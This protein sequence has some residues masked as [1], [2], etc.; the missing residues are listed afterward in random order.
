MENEILKSPE[1]TAAATP[2]ERAVL[3]HNRINANAKIVADSIVEIGR[4]LKTMR[5]EKLYEEIGCGSFAEYCEQKTPIK[6]RQAY[7]FIK[8]YEKYGEE[9]LAEISYL[10]VTKLV[11]L[12]A[13]EDND[14][15]EIIDSG[16]ADNISASELKKKIDEL[17]KANE[18][19]TL[20]LDEKSKEESKIEKLKNEYEKLKAEKAAQESV[21]AKQAERN[22]ELERQ[23]KE[24]REK[25][26]EVAV[27]KPSEEELEEIRRA[28]AEKA[29]NAAKVKH[30]EEIA[31]LREKADDE[32]L[33]AVNAARK[34][35]AEE[36]E[37]LKSQ[38]SD[39]QSSAKKAEPTSEKE[40]VKI[41]IE[42]TMSNFNKA[43]QAIQTLPESEREKP[44]AALKTIVERMKGVF[45]D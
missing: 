2:Q 28:A 6:Q 5:D 14:A 10:G 24:L 7:N 12:A 45:N 22:S 9:R 15:N 30:E 29:E 32:R 42:E 16:D 21:N 26:V 38:I 40:R 36:I 13:I 19:L 17:Q 4:D 11:M 27:Q 1:E 3:L 37:R 44:T 34:E 25:P 31:K 33:V 39:L 41:Y 20:D 23:I 18:Q 43:F 8:C 35:S